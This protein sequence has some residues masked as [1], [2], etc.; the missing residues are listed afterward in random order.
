MVMATYLAMD[1]ASHLCTRV[2]RCERARYQKMQNVRIPAHDDNYTSER[3]H[4]KLVTVSELQGDPLD[5]DPPAVLYLNLPLPAV[6]ALQVVRTEQMMMMSYSLRGW[7]QIQRGTAKVCPPFRF[8][9]CCIHSC[10]RLCTCIHAAWLKALLLVYMSRLAA[11]SLVF[12][13][14]QPGSRCH[15]IRYLEVYYIRG[16]FV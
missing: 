2:W 3:K 10:V 5:H 15:E 9:C 16:C 4:A 6:S 7:K 8:A 1:A 14:L 12:R 11:S 13:G